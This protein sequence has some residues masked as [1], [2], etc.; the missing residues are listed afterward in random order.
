[1][2]GAFEKTAARGPEPVADTDFLQ[3]LNRAFYGLWNLGAKGLVGW[4]PAAGGIQVLAVPITTLFRA[5]GAHPRVFVDR[6]RMGVQ[7]FASVA[8]QFGITPVEIPLPDPAARAP[9]LPLEALIE[10]VFAQYAVTT[11]HQRA[12]LLIGIDEFSLFSPEQQAA[13]LTMLEFALNIAEEQVRLKGVPIDLG[14]S[15]TGDGF[16]LWNRNKG[17]EADL[18]LFAVFMLA[19][20]VHASMQQQDRYSYVPA[21]RSCFGLGSHYGY[22]HPNPR[23]PSAHDYI[24]GDVT[25]RLARLIEKTRRNQIVFAEFTRQLDDKATVNTSGFLHHA[26]GIVEMLRGRPLGDSAIERISTYLTGPKTGDGDFQVTRLT[27]TDK[28]GVDPFAYNAKVNV[29][30]EDGAPIYLGLQDRDVPA[31]F[32]VRRGG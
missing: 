32:T 13:Q 19:L 31:E 30:L 4:T 20:A 8:A 5:A 15:T 9:G 7:T 18:A 26:A 22:A 25:I 29:F 2:D 1:M 6:R 3:R 10:R 21:I 11:T 16:Y 12:V 28:H 24:V 17:F 23:E 27:I 14:R